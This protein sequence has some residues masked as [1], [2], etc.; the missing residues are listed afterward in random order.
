[1]AVGTMVQH[2]VAAGTVRKIRPMAASFTMLA[3]IVFYRAGQP[4]RKELAARHLANVASLMPEVFIDELQQAVRLAL[5]IFSQ[6]PRSLRLFRAAGLAGT[7]AV[8]GV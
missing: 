7:P 2:V 6:T 1:M 4:I 8:P 3:P 5:R